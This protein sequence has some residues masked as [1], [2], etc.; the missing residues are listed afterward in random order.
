MSSPNSEWQS[1]P[2]PCSSQFSDS[3]CALSGPLIDPLCDVLVHFVNILFFSFIKTYVCMT[4]SILFT[5]EYLKINREQ[6]SLFLTPHLF[7]QTLL[8]EVVISGHL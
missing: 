8:T 7:P 5:L 2:H 1:L 6:K 4:S 3:S